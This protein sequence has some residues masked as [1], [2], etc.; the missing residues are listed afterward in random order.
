MTR[1]VA[2]FDDLPGMMQ[3]RHEREG[4]HFAYLERHRDRILIGGGLRESLGG[5]FTGGLWVLETESRE[6]AVRLIEEDPYYQS[7]LRR[8]RLLVWGKA[9]E[10]V[11]V[12]L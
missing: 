4:L 8:Y 9:F 6:E 3:V 1:W 2:I 5:A 11:P 10:N 12:T 7:G